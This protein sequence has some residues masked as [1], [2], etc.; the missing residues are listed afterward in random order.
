MIFFRKAR[1]VL[2]FLGPSWVAFR[3]RYALELRTG[4]LKRRSPIQQWDEID[5][6]THLPDWL[7][8]PRWAAS[9]QG[10]GDRC[11]TEADGI[12]LGE[13]IFFSSQ[14]KFLG[15]P[16]DWH[17]NAVS[18][19]SAPRD[20]HWSELG[21]FDFG[22]I[23][24][25]WEPSRFGWAFTLA[26]AHARTGEGR[27]ADIFWKLFE[28]WCAQNPPNAGV[29]WKCGQEATFR[30]MAATFAFA[31][32]GRL[33]SATEERMKLW[34]RF[35]TATGRRINANLDYAL[36]QSNNH[37]VSECVGLITASLLSAKTAEARAW[38]ELGLAHLRSQLDELIYAD[39]GFSQHSLIYHRVLLHDLLWLIA[40]LRRAGEAPPDWLIHKSR[41]ALQFLTML[42]DENSGGGPLYGA[43][44][45]ANVLP[46]DE[47]AFDD[48]RGVIQAG[49]VLLD[50][51]RIYPSGPW[52]ESVFWL[53]GTDPAKFSIRA[54]EIS[55]ERWYAPNGGCFQW[56]SGG[57]RLFFRCPTRFRHRPS[58][59]DMLHV[60]VWWR[61][62]P[63]AHDAG[64]GTYSNNMPPPVGGAFDQ[65]A[66][67]SV[68]MLA[69]REPLEKAGRFL[70]LPWPRGTAQ[71]SE[72][73]QC[74]RASHDAY[75]ADAQIMRAISS[76]QAGVFLVS[77]QI[78]LRQPSQV[79]LHWL[80]ADADW[81]LDEAA[82]TVTTQLDGEKFT[83]SWDSPARATA[84][85]LVRADP[86]SAR[87]WWSRHYLA[88]EPAVSFELLFDVATQLEVATRFAPG[89][90]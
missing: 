56:R 48:L 89:G 79:R 3:L 33:P 78:V 41:S 68:P 45:G 13:F 54:A 25:I 11:I 17:H 20:R 5:A 14:V 55:P 44:D 7:R 12:S 73:Q 58:Q 53:A 10:W 75:G 27:L 8:A 66:A 19:Q 47:C 2:K 83:I 62:R 90:A 23:K 64:T 46:L 21:D 63:V 4:A 29:N 82:R 80:L 49:F 28:D 42:V 43:N 67:H 61:G 88:V 84:A 37:G 26:R 15:N 1:L 50:S 85:S 9:G 36:S 87:G 24:A 81:K 72:A 52:D 71:W 86:A 18:G 34:S 70:Y 31:E 6:R 16:P 22:D 35:V 38:R 76:P 59:A 65:A 77:D 30:L 57:A 60:D 69:G 32:F 40:L 39:G 74:F 51:V